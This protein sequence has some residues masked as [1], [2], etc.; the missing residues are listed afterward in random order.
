[1]FGNNV[2]RE[3]YNFLGLF[4]P[5]DN[6]PA[7]NQVKAGQVIPVKFS[8][9]G[10]QGLNILAS[11]SP[12][13]VKITCDGSA[14]VDEIETVTA[15]N[16]GL[17]YDAASDTYTYVWKTDK[18]GAGTCRQ[19]KVTLTDGTI[20]M[21]NFKFK[22]ILEHR[23]DSSKNVFTCIKSIKLGIRNAAP[24]INEG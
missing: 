21:A 5:V 20:H 13:S 11:G 19:L 16:S 18:S 2:K 24:Q 10:N 22:L 15:S 1:V 23:K 3:R 8:P 7:L 4:Q 9:N 17:S 6:L 12:S 14:P